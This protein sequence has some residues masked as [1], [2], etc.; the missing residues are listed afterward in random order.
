MK[1]FVLSVLSIVLSSSAAFADGENLITF[2]N[3]TLNVCPKA[4]MGCANSINLGNKTYLVGVDKDARQA[5]KDISALIG[6]YQFHKLTKTLPFTVTGYLAERNVFP[7]PTV[8][9][10]VF[11]V[12][13]TSGVVLPR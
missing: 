11:V 9:R 10:T 13:E 2:K 8:T 12:T 4:A 5:E 7:N 6:T 3:A 1:S